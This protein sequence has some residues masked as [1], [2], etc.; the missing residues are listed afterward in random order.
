MRVVDEYANQYK[1][2]RDRMAGPFTPMELVRFLAACDPNP[3]E[4]DCALRITSPFHDGLQEIL[5][6]VVAERRKG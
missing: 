2:P 5:D 6:A 4:S 3:T 1:L